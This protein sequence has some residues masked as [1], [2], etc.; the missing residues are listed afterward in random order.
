MQKFNYLLAP[1]LGLV[2]FLPIA[3]L[4]V[5]FI[6]QSDFG[7]ATINQAELWLYSKNTLFV[8]LGTAFLVLLLGISSAFLSARYVYVGSRFFSLAFVLPLAFPAYIIGYTY[9]GFFE[10]HGI[11]STLVSLPKLKLDILNVYGVVA[12]LSFAMYPYVFILARVSFAS[13]SS[14]V[15]ELV[16]LKQLSFCKAFFYRL[17]AFGV[18]CYFCGVSPCD[19]GSAQ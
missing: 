2:I 4:I 18:S 16:S 17:S 10:F 12:I 19:D 13:I 14:T 5:Y 11:L 7:V 8:L 9:V 15:V 3:S 1:F 6:A